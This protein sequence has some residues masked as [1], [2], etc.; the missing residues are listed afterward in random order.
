MMRWIL[1]IIIISGLLS[2]FLYMKNYQPEVM[3]K[4]IISVDIWKITDFAS[5]EQDRLDKIRFLKDPD[6]NDTKLYLNRDKKQVL[7]NHT[8]F[9]GATDEMVKLSLGKPKSYKIEPINYKLK[10]VYYLPDD[11]RPTIFE[12]TREY[13]SNL[14][15]DLYR[16]TNAQKSSSIDIVDYISCNSS[17]S[18]YSICQ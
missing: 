11:S 2:V 10:L 15:K 9:I 8:V 1:Y 5:Q 7:I 4:F 6:E 16:L 13:N 14:Q 18:N 3:D 12:F 17:D